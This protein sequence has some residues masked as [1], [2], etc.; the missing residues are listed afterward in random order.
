MQRDVGGQLLAGDDAQE[1]G[2][3]D[4]ALGGVTLQGLDQDAFVVAIDLQGDDAGVGGF[5]FQHLGQVFADQGDGSRGL[6]ATVDHGGN[7]TGITTQAA[8]RTFPQVGTHFGIQGE[9]NHCESPG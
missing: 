3:Q 4:V 2:V 5:A 6:V 9:I 1:V 7:V 8:A